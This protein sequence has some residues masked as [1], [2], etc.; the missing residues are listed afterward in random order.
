MIVSMT[1]N[2]FEHPR[3]DYLEPSGRCSTQWVGFF[4]CLLH[5]IRGPSPTDPP[6]PHPPI[7]ARICKP[8]QGPRN[9]F[10]CLAGRYANPIC[11]SRT[12]GYTGW[13]NRF[14]GSL[15]VYK[16]WLWGLPIG[17]L[18]WIGEPAPACQ[19]WFR[20]WRLFVYIYLITGQL[21]TTSAR[22]WAALAWA[23][24]TVLHVGKG[25]RP[26]HHSKNHTCRATIPQLS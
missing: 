12:P 10:L 11:R 5:Y 3:F 2:N 17:A 4:P 13:R 6:I 25:Y 9:R 15:N 18:T 8:F 20:S 16:Y 22:S 26:V 21:E 24:G 19:A 1:M 7:R 23:D 14:L